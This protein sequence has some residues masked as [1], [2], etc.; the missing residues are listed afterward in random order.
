MSETPAQRRASEKYKAKAVRQ[1][2]VRFFPKDHDAY[3][4][5]KS[6]PKIS[7][8]IIGLIRADMEAPR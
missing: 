2:N 8:Y 7:E 5:A 1:L 6:K 4:Y 3:E